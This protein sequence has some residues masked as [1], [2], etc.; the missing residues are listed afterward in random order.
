MPPAKPVSNPGVDTESPHKI[1]SDL[2]FPLCLVQCHVLTGGLVRRPHPRPLR[3]DALEP[4][5]G[6]STSAGLEGAD[7][8]LRAPPPLEP[9]P[10]GALPPTGAPPLPSPTGAPTLPEPRPTGPLPPQGPAPH[11][12][13]GSRPPPALWRKWP[14]EAQLPSLWSLTKDQSLPLPQT[15]TSPHSTGVSDTRQKV[16]VGV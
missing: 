2:L 15:Q 5:A 14:R 6:A 13:P 16:P 1:K 9:R 12:S 10:H 8:Q 11:R 4:Q 7:T 3:P